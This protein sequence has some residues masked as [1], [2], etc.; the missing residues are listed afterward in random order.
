MGVVLLVQAAFII[1]SVLFVVPLVFLLLVGSMGRH[2]SLT[3]QRD[4]WVARTNIKCIRSLFR[5]FLV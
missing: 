5:K 3:I 2:F 1:M 4:S